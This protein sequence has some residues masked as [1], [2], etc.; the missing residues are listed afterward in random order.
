MNSTAIETGHDFHAIYLSVGSQIGIGDECVGIIDAEE[1]DRV[2]ITSETFIG[3]ASQDELR[4]GITS[5][6]VAEGW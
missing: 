2:H 1:T 3:W 6:R 4:E 5:E